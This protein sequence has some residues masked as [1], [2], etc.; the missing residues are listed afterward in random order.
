MVLF[1]LL[2]LLP[3]SPSAEGAVLGDFSNS[4]S[5]EQL[6]PEVV[7]SVNGT[8]YTFSREDILGVIEETSDL[9]KNIAYQSEIENSNFCTYKKS[10]LC[11]M[12]LPYTDNAHIEKTTTRRLDEGKIKI[13]LQTLAQKTDLAPTNAK[14]QMADGKVAIFS[15]NSP[16]IQLDLTKSEK[17]L[18]DYIS[19]GSFKEPLAL[20]FD[21]IDPEITT[22][23]IDNLG[24]TSLLGE[25]VSNFRGS[26]PN[27][28]FN[29]KTAT[30]KFNGLLIKPGEEFSFVGN[31][32]E[33]DGEH[34]YL[35][36]L[37][38]KNDKTE[39]EFGGG[40]C[41]VSTTAFAPR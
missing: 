12:I 22:D 7:L 39:P 33:V 21:K 17:L 34:G 36:E 29:I 6:P 3:N 8:A 32:G 30:Q 24:I 10:L 1:C 20:P 38:I 9:N 23:S 37:V 28:I 40:I 11:R 31:L 4:T 25:G 16:G 26:P 18:V 2:Y 14:L 35:P 41:Q 5:S 27:R 13:F 15:L 19:Q